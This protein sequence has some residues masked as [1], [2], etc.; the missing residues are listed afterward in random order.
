MAR[1]PAGVLELVLPALS[2]VARAEEVLA[3]SDERAAEDWA[4]NQALA[5]ATAK[6]K[7]SVR[8]ATHDFSTVS[9]PVDADS[10][11]QRP[12]EV[13]AGGASSHKG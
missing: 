6:P 8:F 3:D 4:R 9:P 11:S 2:A 7:K 12:L 13:T 5:A 1:S 10:G